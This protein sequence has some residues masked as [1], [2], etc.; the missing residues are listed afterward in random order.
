MQEEV[1]NRPSDD[2][3]SSEMLMNSENEA[4]L[5][6]LGEQEDIKKQQYE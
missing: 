1:V 3:S 6:Q 5:R 4:E 2:M